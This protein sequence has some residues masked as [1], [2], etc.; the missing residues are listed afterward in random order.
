MQTNFSQI[1]LLVEKSF[2][3]KHLLL[4]C[5][6]SGKN[7]S[8]DEEYCWQVVLG[9]VRS[10]SV[11]WLS[12]I[13]PFTI[14]TSNSQSL[15]GVPLSI[16]DLLSTTLAS[17]SDSDLIKQIKYSDHNSKLKHN[18]R[19]FRLSWYSERTSEMMIGGMK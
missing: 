14:H 2:E 13:F 16:L 15:C 17:H 10:V 7:E 9:L 11:I 18:Y 4:H 8:D 6:W 1:L 5:I 19:L 3:G 12:G